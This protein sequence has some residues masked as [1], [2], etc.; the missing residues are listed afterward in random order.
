MPVAKI[1]GVAAAVDFFPELWLYDDDICALHFK[2]VLTTKSWFSVHDW[3]C[4]FHGETTTSSLRR[5]SWSALIWTN[6]ADE[7]VCC[8]S[9]VRRCW[10]SPSPPQLFKWWNLSYKAFPREETDYETGV[11]LISCLLPDLQV[12]SRFGDFLWSDKNIKFLFQFHFN[13]EDFESSSDSSK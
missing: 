6:G 9:E 4:R 10:R 1:V 5:G 2:Q 3:V 7:E 11:I 12:T 13:S 8:L